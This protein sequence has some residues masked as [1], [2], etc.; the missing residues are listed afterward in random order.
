M[1]HLPRLAAA[2]VLALAVMPAVPAAA[3]TDTAAYTRWDTTTDFTKGTSVGLAAKP[4]AMTLG[5]GTSVITYD[6]PRVSGGALH[7]DRGYWTSPWQTTGFAAK[8]LIPSWS[9]DTP[10]GTWA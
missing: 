2:T 10:V 5:S 6:D 3:A 9:V 7:Y 4:S 1:R 8:S